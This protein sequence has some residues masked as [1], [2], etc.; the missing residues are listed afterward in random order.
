MPFIHHGASDLRTRRISPRVLIGVA[1][2]IVL[3]FSAICGSALLDMRQGDADLA[4]QTSENLAATI[5]ADIA[6]NIELYDLSLRAV[7]ANMALPEIHQ[8]GKPLR[9]LI[10]FD[11]AATAAHFGAMQVMDSAGN[12]TIDSKTLDPVPRNDA[13][14][15]YFTV[16]KR[17][18]LFGLYI[19]KPMVHNGAYAIVLSRRISGSDG[20]FQGVVAGSLRFS[21]FH[22]LIG[23]L[24]LRADDSITVVRQDGIA[25]MRSPFDMD[26]IG[27]DMSSG[28]VV[29]RA[30]AYKS[31]SFEGSG[32]V[33]DIPRLYVWKDG[34]HPLVVI[35]G[36][37]LRDIYGRWRVEAT[38]IAAAAFALALLVCVSTMLL[39]RETGKRSAAE[40]ALLRLAT[41]DGLTG[42]GNRRRF[43]AV[44]QSEWQRALR[45]GD[46][47]ALLMIDADHFKSYNDLFGHQAGDKVLAG[48]ASCIVDTVRRTTDCS[49]R[50]GGEEF[51]V[52]MLGLSDEEAFETA[53]RIRVKVK[54]LP[55]EVPVSVSVG[56]ACV[57]P[58]PDMSASE[59]VGAADAALYQA[60]ARGRDQ[61]FAAFSRPLGRDADFD[62]RIV[63]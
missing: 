50:Y 59:L 45:S 58:T 21:F 3:G 25:I 2:V 53:E 54:S 55:A 16:H 24:Q 44:L 10:L 56:V 9:Q 61:T 14:E 26:V 63:A 28:P 37:S 31:G 19:S 34:Y 8:V 33:D 57:I 51:A 5:D 13:D 48:I 35:V 42:L 23:R 6:G 46:R 47:L 32:A 20:S 30:L 40:D 12:V 1:I 29:Q 17:D 49:A 15:D 41:T 39:V 60:K 22:D 43:D 7:V 4:R 36:K 27:R 38:R 18:P 11:H 52:L 62:R